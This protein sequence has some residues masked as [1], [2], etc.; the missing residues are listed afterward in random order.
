[1]TDVNIRE[2]D[3]GRQME[4]GEGKRKRKF[5]NELDAGERSQVKKYG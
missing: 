5:R 4:M 3:E 2:K 1:M